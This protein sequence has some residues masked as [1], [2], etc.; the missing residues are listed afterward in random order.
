MGARAGKFDGLRRWRRRLSANGWEQVFRLAWLDTRIRHVGLRS[1][2]GQFL[3]PGTLA[4]VP[5]A[6]HKLL[7]DPRDDKIGLRILHG[8]TWH[9]PNFDRVLTQLDSAACLAP[10]GTFVDVGANIGAMTIYALLSGRFTHAVA[11]EPDPHNFS[12]LEQNIAINGLSARVTLIRAAAGSVAGDVELQRDQRN[13]GAHTIHAK[14]VPTPDRRTVRVRCDQLDV[15]LIAILKLRAP[16]S[17]V[18]IDVEG[19]ELEVL[20]GMP[21]LRAR[22]VPILFEY[23][24]AV[25]GPA[26]AN[27]LRALFAD[28]YNDARRLDSEPGRKH[29][30]VSIADFDPGLTESDI[31]VTRPGSANLFP[32]HKRAANQTPIP[33][34]VN[35]KFTLKDEPLNSR[36]G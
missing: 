36:E 12:I 33:A 2:F 23:L 25:H 15:L 3:A 24:G 4:L 17:F 29:P 1:L 13:L 22:S 6:D 35:R 5:F 31:V 11:I 19:H 7:V 8:R 28:G 27:R 18:K 32:L 34:A 9:R 26:G 14:S 20:A 16:V 10:G 21:E 30:A